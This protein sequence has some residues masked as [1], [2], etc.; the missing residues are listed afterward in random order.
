MAIKSTSPL[1][2]LL[3]LTGLLYNPSMAQQAEPILTLGSLEKSQWVEGTQ[4]N[5]DGATRDFY[6]RAASLAWDNYLGDWIDLNGVPQGDTPFSMTTLID[7]N[8][9]EYS[10]WDLTTV[11]QGWLDETYPNKGIILRGLNGSGPYNF[12][13]REHPVPGERPELVLQT[14][15][16]NFTLAPVADVYLEPSTYQGMGDLDRLDIS[17]DRRTLLR[18]NFDTLPHAVTVQSA[19]LRLFVYAEY[20]SGTMD[21]GIFLC[22]QGHDAVDL[23]PQYGLSAQYPNDEGIGSDPNVFL[24]SDFETSAWGAPWTFGTTASTLERVSSDPGNLFE[25]WQG[26]ALRSRFLK[27]PTPA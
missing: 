6:N 2:L 21:A 26:T 15:Q 12:Y 22:N 4:A 14:D 17:A 5:D 9:P 13:S 3:I 25:N 18:F 7:D 20:G 8:T 1:L 16:G 23:G 27:G 11:V 19:T 10:E 24:F